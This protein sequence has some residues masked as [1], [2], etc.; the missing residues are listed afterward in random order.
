MQKY[1]Q[2]GLDEYMKYLDMV[3]KE[4]PFHFAMTWQAEGGQYPDLMYSKIQDWIK[5]NLMEGDCN[6]LYDGIGYS[7]TYCFKYSDSAAAF[8]LRWT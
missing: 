4:F 3:K 1:D 5:E 6:I 2:E 7:T 8:K